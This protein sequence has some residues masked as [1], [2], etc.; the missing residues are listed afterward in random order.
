ML[1]ETVRP[2][3]RLLSDE[4]V[5]KIIDEG[6][7]VLW[8]RGV[9]VDNPEAVDLLTSHGA[10]T[11]GGEKPRLR[12]PNDLV[13]RALATAPKR[14]QVYDIDRRPALDLSGRNV[15]FDPGSA[16]IKFL[17][18]KKG[19]VRKPE[20][21]DYIDFV[22]VADDLEYIDAQSTAMIPADVPHAV[23]DSY[24]LFLSLHCCKKPIVTGAFS[25]RGFGPMKEMLVAIRGDGESLASRPLAVFDVC[26]SSPLVWHHS[27]SQNLLDCARAGIPAEL[28]SMPL[29]GAIGPVTLAGSLVQHTAETLSGIVMHQL[30]Q[31]GS[32]VI[33]GGSPAIF[34]MRYGTTPM[35]AIDSLMLDCAYVEIGNRLG[36]PTHAYM[37]LSDSKL[38][39]AQ[40]GFEAGMGAL[41]AALAGVN[42]VSGAGML[43]FESCQSIEKL[44]IDNEICGMTKRLLEG[45]SVREDPIALPILRELSSDTTLLTHPHTLKWY[46]EEHFLPSPVVD[47]SSGA[48]GP[49]SGRVEAWRRAGQ[50]AER[51]LREHRPDPLPADVSSELVRIMESEA[52]R[53]GLARLPIDPHLLLRHS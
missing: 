46:K 29:A 5:T 8:Q 39:D 36:L 23:A 49:V 53:H 48:E 2:T 35:G 4:T 47:R 51:I 42:V 15:H 14:I 28:V 34:D 44:V 22:R 19:L 20:T 30:A 3:L 40:C 16:A 12:I 11:D 25:G 6:V 13:S 33:Y 31:S 26:P 7:E 17:D 18:M 45:I 9:E 10:K 52:G 50:R 41:L 21:Q 38:L 24:R 43:D 1:P 27:T 37:G 32:P